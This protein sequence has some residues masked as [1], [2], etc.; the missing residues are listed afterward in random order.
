MNGR[1]TIKDIAKALNMHHSTVSRALRSDSRVKEKTRKMVF[2]YAEA[3]G[4]QVNMSA[5]HLRG[6]IR[7]VIAVIVPN[8]NHNFFSNIISD[9]T[10]LAEKQGYMVS[11]FQSNESYEQEKK[12]IDTIIQNNVAGVMVSVA[13]ETTNS[14][15][16][17]KLKRYG[18]PLVLFDRIIGDINVSKVVVNNSEII[19]DAVEL[20]V[21]K[22]CKRI[23][24]ISGPQLVNVFSERHQG[25]LKALDFHHLDYK[26]E[27]IINKGFNL[28]DGKE[29]IVKLLNS[30]QGK[31]D[32]LICDSNILLVG[33]LLELKERGI[34]V[35][36]SLQIVGFSDNPFI[37]AFTPGL[38]CIQQPDEIVSESAMRLLMNNINSEDSNTTESVT[39]SA[40]IVDKSK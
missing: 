34:A 12:I 16:F 9:V 6:S 36:E 19:A 20:L 3:H 32:G 38:V 13:M 27:V 35:P 30:A 14:E 33:V 8:V 10:N 22:G 40:R 26:E 11:V 1:I 23:A 31:P 2:D 18:I 29:A 25:Y 15:H 21:D 24:H 4:Y 5:L 17:K 39:V 37:E 28:E 7:N